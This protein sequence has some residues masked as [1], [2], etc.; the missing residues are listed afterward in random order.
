M[1]IPRP[2]ARLWVVGV[3]EGGGRVGGRDPQEPLR[4]PGP[5]SRMR[6]SAVSWTPATMHSGSGGRRCGA[7]GRLG[8]VVGNIGTGQARRKIDRG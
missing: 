1:P 7:A 5:S 4:V 3:I 2:V 6:T 8:G